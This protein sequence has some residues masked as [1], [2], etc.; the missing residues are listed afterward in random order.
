MITVTITSKRHLAAAQAQYIN[1]RDGANAAE[2][3]QRAVARMLDEWVERTQVD[4]L[5]VFQF[6]ER[7]TAAEFAAITAAGA[8]DP[9]VAGILATLRAR[10][11]VRLGSADAVNGVAYLVSVG[12]L[13]SERGAAVLAY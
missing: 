1:S 7:F 11:S 13:T 5:S 12:L 9:N 10:D 2:C 6:V 3:V 8:N 4:V